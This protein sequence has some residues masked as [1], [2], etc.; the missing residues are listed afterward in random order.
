MISHACRVGFPK[1]WPDSVVLWQGLREGSAGA[2]F[3]IGLR[4]NISATDCGVHAAFQKQPHMVDSG[5]EPVRPRIRGST[6]ASTQADE[7]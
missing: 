2:E 1:E 6:Q 7:N 3:A 4:E 5:W